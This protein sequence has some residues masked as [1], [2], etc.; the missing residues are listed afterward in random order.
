MANTSDTNAKQDDVSDTRHTK[1]S[2]F[3]IL[4][5]RKAVMNGIGRSNLFYL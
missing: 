2:A 5:R 3:E 1:R 4:Y